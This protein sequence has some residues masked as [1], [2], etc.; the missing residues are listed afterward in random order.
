[1][2]AVRNIRRRGSLCH[3]VARVRSCS[4]AHCIH[5][6][7]PLFAPDSEHS[8]PKPLEG[9]DDGC[10]VPAVLGDW[11][12]RDAAVSEDSWIRI[13]NSLSD[14]PLAAATHGL[15]VDLGKAG[16]GILNALQI[17]FRPGSD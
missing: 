12:T 10:R 4:P 13:A 2:R 8:W 5:S 11:R 16:D 14:A 1:M 6:D 9:D 3:A 17:G 7:G 15:L